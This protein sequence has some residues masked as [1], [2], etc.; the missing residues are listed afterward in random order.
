MLAANPDSTQAARDL[1]V[2]LER[3]AGAGGEREDGAPKALFEQS[4]QIREELC[5]READNLAHRRELGLALDHIAR[6]A[7]ATGDGG[8]SLAAREACVGA[9]RAVAEAQ[10]SPASQLELAWMVLNHAE[11]LL[12]LTARRSEAADLIAAASARLEPLRPLAES[13]SLLRA[14]LARLPGLRDR[15]SGDGA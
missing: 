8:R 9:L 14:A 6:L 5:R 11:A 7:A 12:D 15:A 4:R 10:P 2:S 3:L 13:S 1:K